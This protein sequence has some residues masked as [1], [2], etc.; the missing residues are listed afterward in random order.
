MTFGPLQISYDDAVLQPRPWTTR[1]SHWAAE[2]LA[3]APAGRVLELCAGAG[4]IGLLAI[5]LHPREL[6]CVES[7]RQA[8]AFLRGNAD[9]AGLGE[10]VEVRAAD[11]DE[12]LAPEERFAVVIADPP[13]VPSDEIGRF[14]DD[15]PSS[16]DGGADGL[17]PA[18]ACL[19][20][21]GRHLLPGG[22]VVL[23]LGTQA[24]AVALGDESVELAGLQVREVRDGD[25]GVI[26]HLIRPGDA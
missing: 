16:I 5:A 17:D 12:A 14:P 22:G 21:A 13:W 11:L 15:P 4:Q 1:Q 10:L 24:Q 19:R 9:A 6:V 3:E 20:V 7:S 25:G 26:V 8:C 23:Q 2:L 18:R